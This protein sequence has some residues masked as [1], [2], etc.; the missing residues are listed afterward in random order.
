MLRSDRSVL[1]SRNLACTCTCTYVPFYPRLFFFPSH[2]SD[3][4]GLSSSSLTQT[5]QLYKQVVMVGL[6][7]M[8]RVGHI[9]PHLTTLSLQLHRLRCQTD[10]L[11]YSMSYVRTLA[12][13]GG[14]GLFV[15]LSP[16]LNP[17]APYTYEF[18][19]ILRNPAHS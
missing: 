4:N 13:A 9:I 12:A 3:L 16:Y 2:S 14:R 10:D 11:A 1:Q 6:S 17:L 19:L 8:Y 18:P 7:G 5:L 15:F